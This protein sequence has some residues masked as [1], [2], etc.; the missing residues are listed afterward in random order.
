LGFIE[1][2]TVLAE[3]YS[4]A[5][6]FI[7]PSIDDNLPNTVI[8]SLMCG[9]PVVGFRTGGIPDVISD[10]ENGYICQSISPQALARH[11]KAYYKIFRYF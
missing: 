5:D 9:T 8:E 7:I 10:G 2:E 4:A 1:D 3:I 11:N 6:L